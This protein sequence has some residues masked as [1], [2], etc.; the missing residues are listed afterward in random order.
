MLYFHVNELNEKTLDNLHNWLY[1]S[2][3]SHLFLFWFLTLRLFYASQ[4]FILV[5]KS[6]SLMQFSCQSDE[7]QTHS[8]KVYLIPPN[9]N[10]S[11]ITFLPKL[12]HMFKFMFKFF[13]KFMF[14]FIVNN[15]GLKLLEW[16]LNERFFKSFC[17]SK[18]M[19]M[20][21]LENFGLIYKMTWFDC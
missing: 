15:F 17:K 10:I 2:G 6:S 16:R 11:T 13:F 4:L 20:R 3:S 9:T 18:A 19:N 12:A 5:F 1:S 8:K 14:K 21:A 7:F